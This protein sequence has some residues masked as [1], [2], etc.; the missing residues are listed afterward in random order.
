MLRGRGLSLTLD[1]YIYMYL[2][3]ETLNVAFWQV[4]CMGRFGGSIINN[5]RILGPTP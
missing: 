4:Q 3:R 2:T 1:I 5:I